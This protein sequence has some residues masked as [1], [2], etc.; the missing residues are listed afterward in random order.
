MKRRLNIPYPDDPGYTGPGERG[1]YTRDLNAKVRKI[2]GKDTHVQVEINMINDKPQLHVYDGED[3]IGRYIMD[4]PEATLRDMA[5]L[6][7]EYL[8]YHV[9]YDSLHRAL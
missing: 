7:D 5:Q 9:I 2:L 1:L 4:D 6:D 8:E 3:F